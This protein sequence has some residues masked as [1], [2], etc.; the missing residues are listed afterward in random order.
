MQKNYPV[1]Y[2]A[3]VVIE[4]ATPMMLASGKSG[5]IFDVEL[6]RDANGLPTIPGTGL[7]GVLRHLYVACHDE[8]SMKAVFG[9]QQGN[10]GA[11]SRV[12][13]SFGCVH[14]GQNKPIEG[15]ATLD[16][17]D[18]VIRLLKQQQ[19]I[20]RDHVRLTHR[21]VAADTA[22]YDRTLTPAGT[23]FS[24][25]LG[26]LSDHKD[27]PTWD[28]LVTLLHHPRFRLGAVTRAGLGCLKIH[29]LKEAC[30]DLRQPEDIARWLSHPKRLAQ[31]SAELKE[32]SKKPA[33]TNDM[34]TVTLTLTAEDAWRIGSGSTSYTQAEKEADDLILSERVIT[35]EGNKGKA[36]QE[37]WVV[38][39]SG[40]KGA[41]AH[42]VLYHWHRLNQRY[43]ED[44]AQD[45]VLPDIKRNIAPEVVA[46]L[47]DVTEVEKGQTAEAYAGR[48]YFTDCYI[49]PDP[50]KVSYRMHN[51][52]DR[53]TGGTRDGALFSEEVI[54]GGTLQ[55]QIAIDTQTSEP[56]STTAREALKA[57]LDDLS[58]G[59]MGL[60]AGAG[61]GM[62]YFS[63]TQTWAGNEQ[64]IHGGNQ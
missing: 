2:K 27:D 60:G 7:A 59:R 28:N 35:W 64:W 10:E 3:R 45:G 55:L 47:G 53:F 57:A 56:I 31:S 12:S 46:L 42:R 9:Y 18:A 11:A 36:D 20:V 4:C 44:L 14:D 23:R 33:V 39:G 19:P 30:F 41:I 16:E 54:E 49:N 43:A 8:S 29:S 63:G 13:V 26:Y 38:P 48:V 40:V 24:F 17:Q 15:L 62:G 61:K 5:D 21:G 50:A 1:V 58:Q 51:S 25:E 6:I 52:I 22:K 37:K 34:A 32:R